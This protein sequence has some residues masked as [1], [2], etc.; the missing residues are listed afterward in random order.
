MAQE[1]LGVLVLGAID[2]IERDQVEAHVRTCGSCAAQLAELAPLPGLLKRVDASFLESTPAPAAILARALEQIRAQEPVDLDVVRRSRR[3]RASWLLAA[4][5]AAVVVIAGLAGA[6]SAQVFPFTAPASIVA[7]AVNPTTG[8][9]ATVTLHPAETG[10]Q[11]LLTLSGVAPGARC[12]LVAVGKDGQREVAATWVASYDGEAHVAGT[13]GLPTDQ[14][15]SFD[16]TTPAGSALVS[17]PL[18][19]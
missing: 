8:V 17:V 6:K 9:S 5:A 7:S 1:S 16:I 11:V 14:I 10:T 19:A 13:T 15:A 4:A 2:P 12:Q 3:P 18:S